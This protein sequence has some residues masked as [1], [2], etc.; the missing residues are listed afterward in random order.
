MFEQGS[1][2]NAG[3]IGCVLNL[4]PGAVRNVT[5]PVRVCDQTVGR[6]VNF[7]FGR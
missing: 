6:V 5:G 7:W 1:E 2:I 3:A 4:Y